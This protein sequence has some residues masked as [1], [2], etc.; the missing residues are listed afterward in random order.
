MADFTWVPDQGVPRQRK[1]RVNATQFGD[2]YV[3]RSADGINNVTEQ[4]P[5][6]FTLR[7]IA[8]INAID[9]FLESKFGVSSFTWTNPRG[10]TYRYTCD[11]WT[12]VYNHDGNCSLTCTFK[13]VFET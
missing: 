13:R 11:E 1:A 10:Q 3:Q 5:L 8:T 2:G 9:D 7:T 12:P 6:T 4:V